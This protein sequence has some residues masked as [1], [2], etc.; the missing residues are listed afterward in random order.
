MDRRRV[1]IYSNNT[2]LSRETAKRLVSKLEARGF[3]ISENFD[4]GIELIVCVGGDGTLLRLLPD[5]NYPAMPIVG[6][7]TGHMGFFQEFGTD[8]LDELADIC[9]GRRYE[10]Q[11]HQL[12]KAEVFLKG[13]KLDERRAINDVLIR[14]NVSRLTHLN[15]SIGTTYIEHFSGDG[16]VVSTPVGSTAYNYSLGGAI[17]DPRLN[18]IQVSPVAPMNAA[19]FRSFTSSLLL[20]PDLELVVRP[21][22]G[23][24]ETAILS[25]DGFEYRYE[26]FTEICV[27]LAEEAVVIARSEGFDFWAKVSSKFL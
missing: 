4:E 5:L 20:P 8:E 14:N 2:D 1:F 27:G 3:L 25:V 22:E 9:L 21:C 11:R 19:A 23:F 12:I 16:I 13:E 26:S 7:N 6:V 10:L 24:E 15:L 17:V 18:V